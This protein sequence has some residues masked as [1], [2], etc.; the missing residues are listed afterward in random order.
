[1]SKFIATMS[2]FCVGLALGIMIMIYGWGLEPKSWW[3]I[4][5]GGIGLRLIVLIIEAIVKK[6]D[7]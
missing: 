7:V 5:G 1:M 3:W 4:L 6:E 2:M